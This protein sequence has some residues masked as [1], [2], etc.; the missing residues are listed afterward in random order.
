M[1]KTYSK[2]KLKNADLLSW[3]IELKLPR[4]G[5]LNTRMN[6][7]SKSSALQGQSALQMHYSILGLFWWG[8]EIVS[9]SRSQASLD[10]RLQSLRTVPWSCRDITTPALELSQ[11]REPF[12]PYLNA[13]TLRWLPRLIDAL[14]RPPHCVL[15]GVREVQMNRGKS[16]PRAEDAGMTHPTWTNPVV[17][18]DKERWVTSWWCSTKI[19]YW[20]VWWHMPLFP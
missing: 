14:P 19:S 4:K 16:F 18:S 17:N 15:D 6:C 9:V 3:L 10:W 13:V 2:Q 5:R 12:C 20:L 8:H 7:L 1:R 11:R